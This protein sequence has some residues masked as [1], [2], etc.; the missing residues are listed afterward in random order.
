MESPIIC[1]RR[2]LLPPGGQRSDSGRCGDLGGAVTYAT[3]CPTGALGPGRL[4]SYC[5]GGRSRLKGSGRVW[6]GRSSWRIWVS[7]LGIMG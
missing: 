1:G 2:P 3:R 5:M 6:K 4:P 7:T